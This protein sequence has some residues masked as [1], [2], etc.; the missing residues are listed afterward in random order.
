[1]DSRTHSKPQPS[2][3][4]KSSFFNGFTASSE[5]PRAVRFF[6]GLNQDSEFEP[7]F[8]FCQ[9]SIHFG[10]SE[11]QSE[12]RSGFQPSKTRS[13]VY[14]GA[15]FDRQVCRAKVVSVDPQGVREE[16]AVTTSLNLVE[17]VVTFLTRVAGRHASGILP[18][19][20]H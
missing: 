5:P 14:S 1:M 17:V 8:R 6:S 13:N 7:K 10:V 4:G 3:S 11:F 19:A 18:L 12:A 15:V 9:G 2:P 20:R 16:R